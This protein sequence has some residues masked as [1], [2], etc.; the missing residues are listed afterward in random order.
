MTSHAPKAL[1]FDLGGVLVDVDFSRALNAWSPLSALS[2]DELRSAFRFDHAYERHERGEITAV[3][4]FLHLKSALQLTATLDQIEHG[5][6]AIFAGEI[7]QT[8]LLVETTRQTL[9]CFA[10]TNT[11]ASH[12]RHS[13]GLYP[14]VVSAFDRIFASHEIGLRKPERAAFDYICQQLKLAPASIL[15]FDDL[16]ENVRAAQDAGLR[17]VHVR[18]PDDVAEALKAFV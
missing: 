13:A 17:A 8:R 12:F 6:N 14:K 9:P 18:G 3:E 4:Y 16:A 2:P 15:F 11:N 5:W 1:L 7:A 10:F